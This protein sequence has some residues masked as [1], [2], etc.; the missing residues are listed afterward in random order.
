MNERQKQ[1]GHDAT[2]PT[3]INIKRILREQFDLSFEETYAADVFPFI[4]EGSMGAKN[5]FRDLVKSASEYAV[6]QIDI[7]RPKMVIC[8]GSAPFNAIRSSTNNGKWMPM[9]NA[10]MVEAPFHTELTGVPIFGVI[11]VGG[12][13]TAFA[14]GKAKLEPRWQALGAHFRSIRSLPASKSE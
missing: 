11:H 14:G 7:V 13:A 2:L 12:Q 4:K 5:P 8:L 10:Y 1:C 6:P 3:N 9:K